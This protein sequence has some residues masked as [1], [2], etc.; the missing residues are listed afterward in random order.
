M[1]TNAEYA[2]ELADIIQRYNDAAITEAQMAS[3]IEALTNDWMVMVSNAALVQQLSE[4]VARF[5]AKW[6][7]LQSLNWQG[8]KTTVAALPVSAADGDV[9]FVTEAQ[10]GY[11]NGQAFVWLD[12]LWIPQGDD[13]LKGTQGDDGDSAY[14]VAVA[15][16]FVGNEAAW[17]ASLTGDPGDEGPS[18]YD[19]AVA[20]GFVGNEAAWLAS[21]VGPAGADGAGSDPEDT[22][23]LD[24]MQAQHLKFVIVG[25]GAPES[26][27]AIDAATKAWKIPFERRGYIRKIFNYNPNT[28]GNIKVKVGRPA[29]T[30]TTL[31]ADPFTTSSGSGAVSVA[32]T[33][34]G[35]VAGNPVLFDGATAVGGLTLSGLY[36]VTS[37]TDA[38]VYVVTAAATA[39]STATGGGAAV[40]ETKIRF[41]VVKDVTVSA[42]SGSLGSGAG[43]EVDPIDFEEGD[44]LMLFAYSTN[45]KSCH[46]TTGDVLTPHYSISGDQGLGTTFAPTSQSATRAI[47]FG[48]EAVYDTGEVETIAELNVL[49]SYVWGKN[50]DIATTGSEEAAPAGIIVHPEPFRL[51]GPLKSITAAFETL[52]GKQ[53]FLVDRVSGGRFNNLRPFTIQATASVQTFEA[54]VDMPAGLKVKRNKT[55]LAWLAS[56]GSAKFSKSQGTAYVQTYGPNFILPL[57]ADLTGVMTAQTSTTEAAYEIRCQVDVTEA[58][59]ADGVLIDENFADGTFPYPSLVPS[60]TAHRVEPGKLIIGEA[61]VGKGVTGRHA[62]SWNRVKLFASFALKGATEGGVGMRPFGN[63]YGSVFTAN[64]SDNKLRIFKGWEGSALPTTGGNTPYSTGKYAEITDPFGADIDDDTVVLAFGEKYDRR[65]LW[66]IYDAETFVMASDGTPEAIANNCTCIVDMTEWDTLSN[67]YQY[68]FDYLG[69]FVGAPTGFTVTGTGMEIYHLHASCPTLRPRGGLAK[70]SMGG[71][72][73]DRDKAWEYYLVDE[74]DFIL[75][76]VD[77][78]S[79]I[80]GRRLFQESWWVHPDMKHFALAHGMVDLGGGST[81]QQVEDA[82][83]EFV[84]SIEDAGM[85]PLLSTV[86]PDT[87]GGASISDHIRDLAEENGYPLAEFYRLFCTTPTSG[88]RDDQWFFTQFGDLDPHL[89]ETYGHAR[90]RE[91]ARAAWGHRLGLPVGEPR[92][93]PRDRAPEV[94]VQLSDPNGVSITTGDGKAYFGIT[95]NLDL[96][97]ITAVMGQLT[98]VSS[99]G[100][101]TVQIHHV[102]NS[103]DLLSTPLTIDANERTSLTAATKAV[104]AGATAKV[105]VGDLLRFD[106]DTA[107]TGAKGLI[108]TLTF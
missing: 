15:N 97:H 93:N 73:A 75:H 44:C 34:H 9:W 66:R 13:L 67:A 27:T 47:Q 85:S 46:P 74:A 39:T 56:A 58:P 32:H 54:G 26:G 22:T 40:V 103:V 6:V 88:V 37:V 108:I 3:E 28:T 4:Q 69:Q 84:R 63:G 94:Q 102:Q 24:L 53:M 23:R 62:Q 36:L 7:A 21:L 98:T 64:K 45:G 71:S 82:Y 72:R 57:T 79:T 38:N 48:V 107:G 90:A 99:S 11:P 96:R 91:V 18:A 60:S 83:T 29:N 80:Q 100:V 92:V 19:V 42:T 70:D 2:V 17:L 10:T 89:N 31:G 35:L 101:V 8:I 41:T 55:H 78:N 76:G 81:Q 61:G 68:R 77:G 105:A 14:D 20:N 86:F 30:T 16:G 5:D 65:I 59:I 25:A 12:G 1:L 51:G 106:I 95:G 104:I 43:L 87:D 49:R 50:G 33:A 52:G